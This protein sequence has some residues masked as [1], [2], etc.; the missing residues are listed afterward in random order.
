MLPVTIAHLSH[1]LH[2]QQLL[3]D[4]L[5]QKAALLEETQ[6]Y[7][8]LNDSKTR[9]QELDTDDYISTMKD[10]CRE[11]GVPFSFDVVEGG[12]IHDDGE[13]TEEKSIVLTFIDVPQNT[14]DAIA[15]KACGLFNQESVLITTDHIRVRSIREAP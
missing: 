1:V 7:I 11:F 8:G 5:R 3:G 6:V 15:K 2:G 14:V 9:E 13:Y 10:V 12:Y 4:A